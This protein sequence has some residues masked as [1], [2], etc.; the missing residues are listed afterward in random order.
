M[1]KRREHST[2]SGQSQ[3]QRP[4]IALQREIVIP[5]HLIRDED[6]D[7]KMSRIYTNTLTGPLFQ[8]FPAHTVRYTGCGKTV[9]FAGHEGDDTEG[10]NHAGTHPQK[11]PTIIDEQ[12]QKQPISLI[13]EFKGEEDISV[14]IS[15]LPSY[16]R[17]REIILQ[18]VQRS[19]SQNDR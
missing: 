7:G 17:Q 11:Y 3:T 5:T 16:N 13:T 10:S 8:E 15:K 14:T 18:D 6:E 4:D 1:K 12:L 2:L 19:L 9:S